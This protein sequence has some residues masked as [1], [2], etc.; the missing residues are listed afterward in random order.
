MI[1][2]SFI[3]D[4]EFFGV[5]YWIVEIVFVDVVGNFIIG[6]LELFVDVILFIIGFNF[7]KEII[8]ENIVFN[9][10]IG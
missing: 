2:I 8:D 7:D 5:G 1:G 10:V 9:S 6:I 4:I 3:G